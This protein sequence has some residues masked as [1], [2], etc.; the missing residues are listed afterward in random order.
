MSTVLVTGGSGFVGSHVILQLL[1]AGHD[2]RTTVR[3]LTREDRCARCWGRRRRRGTRGSPSSPPTSSATT[4]GPR[5]SPAATT[6]M[7]VASPI[8]PV[9]PKT[10]DEL[11]IPARDGVLRVLQ[12]GA[13]R[14]GQARGVH[15][16]VRRDLLRPPAADRAVRRNELDRHSTAR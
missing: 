11:I 8:P 14:A 4:A 10:E 1:D 15:V 12:G 7:H 5:P 3:S 6:C 2:V 9:A 13:R 16:D